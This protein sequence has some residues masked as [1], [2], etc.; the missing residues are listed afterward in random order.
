LAAGTTEGDGR[1]AVSRGYYAVF[2]FFRELLL[3]HGVDIGRSGTS[4]SNL[5]IGL[6]NC[7]FAAAAAIA[8]RIDDLR[9]A[10]TKADYDLGRP[11]DSRQALGT[12]R[13]CAAVIADF[14]AALSA[15]PAAQ[16]AAGAK[17][18]L[19]SIGRIP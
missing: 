11:V 17:K 3:N 7:G 15:T 14:R 8:I 6:N 19:Q 18:H 9:D 1:S 16:I 2:H 12:A 4:H 5:Y 10:R 13:E